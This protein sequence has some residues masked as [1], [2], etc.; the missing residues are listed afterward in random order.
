VDSLATLLPTGSIH[1]VPP[2]TTFA[3]RVRLALEAS[4]LTQ[5]A[6]ETDAKLPKGYV[7]RILK[8]ER[9]RLGAEMID[10]MADVLGVDQS[11]LGTGRGSMAKAAGTS[12]Q[13]SPVAEPSSPPYGQATDT[14]PVALQP[15]GGATALGTSATSTFVV[16]DDQEAILD[17][18]FRRGDFTTLSSVVAR[19]MLK[20]RGFLVKPGADVVHMVALWMG[21]ATRLQRRGELVTP[22]A[23][24]AE[25][26]DKLVE[27]SRPAIEQQNEELRKRLKE[28]LGLEPHDEDPP[29]LAA[30]RKRAMLEEAAL[31]EQLQREA[32]VVPPP[33]SSSKAKAVGGEGQTPKPVSATVKKKSGR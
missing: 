8:G 33:G 28:E 4:G 17:A 24:M 7:S 30:A 15:A 19:H 18:A 25:L 21:A 29:L 32:E 3:D 5:N 22:D 12:G 23:V 13:A 14:A 9:K 31:A 10:R 26:V 1:L 16:D 2:P 27:I 6:L 20:N 11:W